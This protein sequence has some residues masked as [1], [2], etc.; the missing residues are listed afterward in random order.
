MIE[1]EGQLPQCNKCGFFMNNANSPRHQDMAVYEK[2]TIRREWY[3]RAQ[4]QIEAEE[5]TFQIAGV[6][7][8]RVSSFHYLGRILD[9]N[10]DDSHA[11][12][13]QLARARARWGHIASLLWSDGVILQ[14]S[15]PSHTFVWLGNMGINE[16]SVEKTTQFSCES[17]PLPNGQAH[18]TE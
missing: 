13:H 16:L 5:V 1:E 2:Y 12:T 18:T 3:F 17:G 11:L 6:E 15:R 4:H 9:E 8:E 14:G 7:I 10:D